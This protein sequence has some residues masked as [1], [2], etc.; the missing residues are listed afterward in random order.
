MTTSGVVLSPGET[1]QIRAAWEVAFFAQENQE[2]NEPPHIHVRSG[3]GFA[4]Y[5]KSR[6]APG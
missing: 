2:M 5:L 3:N 6:R 4:S 1:H